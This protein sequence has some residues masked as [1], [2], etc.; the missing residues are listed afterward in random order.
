M[1]SNSKRKL[2]NLLG[3]NMVED[4][5]KYLGV[6]LIHFRVSKQTFQAPVD[7]MKNK[8]NSWI[9][10]K[11]PLAG[12]ITVMQSLLQNISSYIMQSMMFPNTV[13]N[14]IDKICRHFIWD[15]S[16]NDR[17]ISLVPWKQIAMPKE[18]GG[19]G[20]WSAKIMNNS[21]LIK[22]TWGLFIDHHALWIAVLYSKYKMDI[23][24]CES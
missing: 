19:L 6:P 20:F 23:K 16:E 10:S 5:D 7:R 2:N 18:L 24:A 8:L 11:L 1:E 14:D 21:F 13:H 9:S 15:S 4:L 3:V 12:R 17:K 22:V